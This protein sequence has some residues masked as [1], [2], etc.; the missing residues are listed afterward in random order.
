DL[1]GAVDA[2]QLTRHLALLL[3]SIMNSFGMTAEIG[4]ERADYNTGMVWNFAVQ[5]QKMTPVVRQQYALLG[6]REC[7]NLCI[8]RRAVRI[9][10]GESGQ[11]V[12][13]KA[14]HQILGGLFREILIRV[15]TGH[16]A[17]SFSRIC[18]SICKGC[19]RT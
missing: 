10:R 4:I 9:P 15:K 19:E 18:S 2:N 1:P 8:R 14:V 7:Q 5:E 12:V 13:A 3:D 17:D 11:Y 16:H 6:S